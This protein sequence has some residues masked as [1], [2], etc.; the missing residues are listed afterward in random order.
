MLDGCGAFGSSCH[1]SS[2]FSWLFCRSALTK[3]R[4]L[5]SV[6]VRTAFSGIALPSEL[7]TLPLQRADL[8]IAERAASGAAK[9]LSA[10]SSSAEAVIPAAEQAVLIL[11]RQGLPAADGESA[12]LLPL[13][14]PPPLQW[15]SQA[16]ARSLAVE[17]VPSRDVFDNSWLADA[18]GRTL[19]SS[20]LQL[21]Q[22]RQLTPQRAHCLLPG[23]LRR[24]ICSSRRS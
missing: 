21:R 8:R 1:S 23:C 12:K 5:E 20:R 2:Q 9:T 6:R 24:K 22:G 4:K 3:R 10:H 15:L 13:P 16:P 14:P 17:Q 11:S 19:C 7:L 18:H